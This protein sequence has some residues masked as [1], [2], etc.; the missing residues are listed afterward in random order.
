M[1]PGPAAKAVFEGRA[2]EALKVV[3]GIGNRDPVARAAPSRA[4]RSDRPSQPAA[5]RAAAVLAH[6][7]GQELQ[8]WPDRLV[9]TPGI[10]PAAIVA[11]QMVDDLRGGGCREKGKRSFGADAPSSTARLFAQA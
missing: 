3:E 1:V 4:C 9:A 7:F 10:G 6:Q 5:S 2:I 11:Q 8:Q